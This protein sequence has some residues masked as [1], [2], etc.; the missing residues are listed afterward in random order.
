MMEI[1][2]EC[3]EKADILLFIW[4]SVF[5]II[6]YLVEVVGKINRRDEK[7]YLNNLLENHKDYQAVIESMKQKMAK[8]E[9]NYMHQ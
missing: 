7:Q 6:E 2:K 8:R 4:N 1:G 5:N 3:R 9:K